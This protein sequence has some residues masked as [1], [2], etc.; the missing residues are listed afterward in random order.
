MN[1]KYLFRGVGI[2]LTLLR[3]TLLPIQVIASEPEN[4]GNVLDTT[5]GCRENTLDNSLVI[6]AITREKS[7]TDEDFQQEMSGCTDDDTFWGLSDS[8]DREVVN[9]DDEKDINTKL[10]FDNSLTPQAQIIAQFRN[11]PNQAQLLREPILPIPTDELPPLP[12]PETQP[13]EQPEQPPE[14][15]PEL[16]TEEKRTLLRALM[17][18]LLDNSATRYPFLVNTSDKLIINPRNFQPAKFQFYSNFSFDLDNLDR[19]NSAQPEKLSTALMESGNISLYPD[20]QQ[21]YW[22]LD[23]NR[24][25]IETEGKHLNV[26][27]QGNASQR[28]QRQ[29]AEVATVFWGVQSVFGLPNNFQDLLGDK[30]LEDLNIIVGSGEIVRPS[31]DNLGEDFSVNINLIGPDGNLLEKFILGDERANATTTELE[32]GGAFFENLDATNAPIFFQGFPTI[33]LQSLLNNGV[34]LEVGSII[35]SEN[36]A[37]AG[38]TLGDFFTKEGF[39]FDAPISSF[40]GVKILRLDQSDNNDI[41]SI[42]S[43]PFLSQQE[44]DFYYLNSLM[45]YNLGQRDPDFFTFNLSNNRKDWSRYTLSWSHNR[46]LLQYDPEEIKLN[47]VN[48]FSNPGLSITTAKLAEADNHQ[49]TNASLGLILGSA[50]HLINPV[51]LNETIQEAKEKYQNLEPL[52]TLNTQATSAQRR[53]MNQRLNDTLNYGN[54]NS[55]LHQ[56]SGSYTFASNITPDSSSLWQL[57]TGLYRRNVLFIGQERAAWSPESPVIITSVRNRDLG[58]IFFTGVNVPTSLTGINYEE[59]FEFTFL[60]LETSDGE[61]LFDQSFV[62]DNRLDNLFTAAPIIGPG[63]AYDLSFGRIKLSRFRDR[64]VQTTFYSGSLYF[65]SVELVTSGTINNFSYALSTGL[66]FNLFPDSAPMIERNL[67]NVIR[68]ATNEMSMGGMLKLSAKADFR[69]IFYD[70]QKQWQTII[71]NSPIF[72]LNYNT[73]PNRLNLSTVS[74]ANVFQLVRRDFNVTLYPVLSYSPQVLNPNVNSNRVG[75]V[76]AFVLMNLSHQSGWKLNSN[77]SFEQQTRY[78]IEA[79]YNVI[80]N[81][82]I[83]SLEIGPYMGNFFR[84]FPGFDFLVG[85]NNYGIKL[86]YQTPNSGFMLNSR[87]SHGS[88]GFQGDL[89]LQFKH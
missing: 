51:N 75:N 55:N 32:G 46:T 78:Q 50:F 30:N 33:N 13:G 64:D 7:D 88:S 15:R 14:D 21:F 76:E 47:Y 35:P 28:N 26:A 63:K 86:Q 52:A 39:A 17:R 73:N 87:I 3:A 62:F 56:V 49:T 43:N 72:S 2:F 37:E 84:S 42:L 54:T 48:V 34:E 5:S 58:P 83:G 11:E 4:P 74:L 59:S 40:P 24:V 27:I 20:E 81:E 31:G 45:W 10:S 19:N 66:W 60:R 29:I 25:V 6:S 16:T 65:P 36:L 85:S 44:R 67:G 61:V 9:E 80:K 71:L 53:Q 8:S 22:V 12:L 77:I 82:K 69:N 23:G 70:D 89:N 68:N 41:V 1:K 79:T 18:N 38:L 57:R